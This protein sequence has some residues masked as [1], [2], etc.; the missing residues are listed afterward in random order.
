MTPRSMQSPR[1]ASF[2]FST[3][4]SPKLAARHKNRSFGRHRASAE[5]RA[6]SALFLV[7]GKEPAERRS[8]QEFR[9]ADRLFFGLFLVAAVALCWTLL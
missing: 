4:T 9:I 6:R 2:P 8:R 5:L 7:P 1:P 3:L